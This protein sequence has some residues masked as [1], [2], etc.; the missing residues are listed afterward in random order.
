MR[1]PRAETRYSAARPSATTAMSSR[2]GP[3]R[4]RPVRYLNNIVEQDHRAI[5]HGLAR[6]GF[7]SLPAAWRKLQV[8]ETMNII[9]KGQVR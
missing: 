8:I 9:R 5:N 2:C 7:W 1:R 4:C 6:K 3:S